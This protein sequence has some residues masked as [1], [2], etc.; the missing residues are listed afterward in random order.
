MARRTQELEI[1][2]DPASGVFAM[3]RQEWQ[4]IKDVAARAWEQP[5]ECRTAF[6]VEI[7]RGDLQLQRD[8]ESLLRS[9]AE[10]ESLYEPPVITLVEPS[11]PRA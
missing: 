8:V 7:C 4:R 10:A 9:V 3:T 1:H 5:R 2:P 11:K 6:V